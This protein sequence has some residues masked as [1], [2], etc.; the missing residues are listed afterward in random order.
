MPRRDRQNFKIYVKDF[1]L[2]FL[3]KK[4]KRNIFL[5]SFFFEQ[6]MMT[7]Q[8]ISFE[9]LENDFVNNVLFQIDHKLFTEY[10]TIHHSNLIKGGDIF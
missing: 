9:N 4:I 3:V 1:P 10:V 5:Y 8:T 6:I 7:F 2:A